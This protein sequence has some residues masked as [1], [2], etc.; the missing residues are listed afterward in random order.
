MGQAIRAHFRYLKKMGMLKRFLTLSWK[1]YFWTCSY[2]YAEKVSL[3]KWFQ[4][5][6]LQIAVY[7][8]P[9]YGHR[10]I[11]LNLSPMSKTLILL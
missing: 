3:L 5:S 8:S 9:L 7:L 2:G 11:C 6:Y 10:G 4:V 1:L